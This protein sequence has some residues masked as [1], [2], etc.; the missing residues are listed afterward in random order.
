MTLKEIKE[1]N[2]GTSWRV[3]VKAINPADEYAPEYKELYNGDLQR[4]PEVLGA[5]EVL[6]GGEIIASDT[7]GHAGAYSL[8]VSNEILKD[9]E[10]MQNI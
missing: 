5:C 1:K 10:I 7:P 6:H 9:V 8:S 3:I 2:K 4:L